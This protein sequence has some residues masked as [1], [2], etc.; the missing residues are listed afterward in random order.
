MQP[1]EGGKTPADLLRGKGQGGSSSAMS[2]AAMAGAAAAVDP[3]D[4]ERLFGE[5]DKFCDLI[6]TFPASAQ[7]TGI[8]QQ[9]D[10]IEGTKEKIRLAR[11]ES[12]AHRQM[13]RDQLM[14]LK[15]EATKKEEAHRRRVQ[16]LN[17]PA[18]PLD[19]DAL[20]RALLKNLGFTH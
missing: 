7:D 1:P 18:P 8:R 4:F 14:R 2:A 3:M 13:V 5:M 10:F 11:T 6:R 9:L 15:E 16:E 19:G 20:G 17:T 12:L